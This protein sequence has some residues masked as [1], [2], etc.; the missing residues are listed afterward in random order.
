MFDGRVKTLNHLIYSSLY[1]RNDKKHKRQFNK[2]N[3]PNI[4]IVVVNFYPFEKYLN[5]I[6]IK[7]C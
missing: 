7:N 3:I 1:K 4:D 2:L 6:K 5:E